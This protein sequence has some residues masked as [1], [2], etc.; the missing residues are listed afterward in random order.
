MICELG[1]QFY[2]LGWVSGTGGGISIREGENLYV[3]PSGVQKE[4]LEP[5]DI[6]VI[7]KEGREILGP[8]PDRGL[9]LSQCTPLFLLAFNLRGA[10]AVV[11]THSKQ[12]VLATLAYPGPEFK[13]THLEMIKGIY[14]PTENRMMRF[15]EEIVVPIIE[16][17]PFER[18][19]AN[20][21][22]EVRIG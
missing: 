21:M 12:A 9:K 11:H 19:L 18:D 8:D 6:F 1:R 10:G 13:V 15:D 17:T 5:R 22:A 14:H 20:S 16:N 2:N 4:R 7:D 3:A